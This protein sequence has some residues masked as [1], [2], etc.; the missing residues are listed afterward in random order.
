ME[1]YCDKVEKAA[2]IS[3]YYELSQVKDASFFD[4]DLFVKTVNEVIDQTITDPL[5]REV[6]VGNLTLYD[7]KKDKTPFATHAF[8]ADLYNKSA[9]RVVGGSDRIATALAEVLRSYGGK[10]VTRRKVEKILVNNK[11]ASGVVT[12]DGETIL[13]DVVVSDV[14]PKQLITMVDEQVFSEKFINRIKKLPD[15]TSVFSLY[16][17]FKENAVPYFNS[18]FYKIR[19]DSC[20]AITGEVDEKWPLGYLYLHYCHQKNPSYAQGG[21]VFAYLSMD[22][23]RPWEETTVG[24]RGED[25]EAYKHKLAEKLLDALEEDFPGIRESIAGYSIATPLT[26]RDYT[27]TPNGSIYGLSRDLSLGVEGRVKYNTRVSNLFLVGQNII[28]HGILGVLSGTM[29]VCKH[30]IGEQEMLRQMIEAN[31]KTAL[32]IGGGIGGLV[33]GALLSKEGYKV[34]V[35]EKNKAI[36]GGLQCFE[37]KGKRYPTGMHVFGGLDEEGS[38]RKLF[39]YLGIM[40]RLSYRSMDKEANDVVVL[41]DQAKEFRFPQGK[42]NYIEYLSSLFPD[43]KDNIKAYVE[44]LIELAH[45]SDLFFLREGGNWKLDY[46]QDFLASFDSI[47]NRY[48]QDDQLK[49]LLHYLTPMFNGIN[50]K[51]PAFI[52]AITT[53]MHIHGTYQFVGGSQQLADLLVGIIEEQGGK[54]LTGKKVVAIKV[55]DREVTEVVAQD[56]SSYHA[57]SYI[58]DI[59]PD[60]LLGVIDP[61]AFTKAYVERLRQIEESTSCFKVFVE[62]KENSFPYLNQTHYAVNNLNRSFDN[63]SIQPEEWPRGVMFVTPSQEHQGDFASTMVINSFM[64]FEWVKPWENTT[65]GHRGESYE[66]WK[67]L[68]T[69]K[70]IDMMAK[71]Y[72]NFRDCIKNVFA[73]SPLTIRDYLGNKDGSIYG[74]QRNCKNIM[75]S[76][77]SVITK[78][79]NLFLTGQNVNL[80]GLCGVSLGAVETVEAIVG[81]NVIVRKINEMKNSNR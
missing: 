80:H 77:L 50:G 57:D 48:I 34:T 45:E 62:F 35:L 14:H 44:K 67:Q 11:V 74:Y 13:A 22:S 7:G 59:H 61:G 32:I 17:R 19:T 20:W 55:K 78:V 28:A 40:D 49:G 66:S 36:G 46:S 10:I 53:M 12:D 63:S 43:E 71:V 16:L 58:S 70:V 42:E 23:M 39:S 15:T 21:V 81:Q 76:Q 41:T 9:F 29:I 31:K 33:S 60:L 30:L 56:G 52:N 18:S 54:V 5:L 2:K 79:R 51:T 69:E 8:I 72:P 3:P 1:C 75:L 26:Y 38:M 68:Y 64:D 4:G 24:R 25:Y 47:I 37:R 65:V 27:L 73:S 6:L